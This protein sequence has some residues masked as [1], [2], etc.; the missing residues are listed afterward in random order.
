MAKQE[1]EHAAMNERIMGLVAEKHHDHPEHHKAI[2]MIRE[3]TRDRIEKAHADVR[4]MLEHG[5]G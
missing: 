3:I 1:I 4:A 2:E 5:T